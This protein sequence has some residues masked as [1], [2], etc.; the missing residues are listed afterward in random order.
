MVTELVHNRP[1]RPCKFFWSPVHFFP[2]IKILSLTKRVYSGSSELSFQIG[3][4]FFGFPWLS[5]HC[6]I[7]AKNPKSVWPE[8]RTLIALACLSARILLSW[9]SQNLP[10]PPRFPLSNFYSLAPHLPQSCSWAINSHFSLLYF[11]LS[12]LQWSLHLSWCCWIKSALW[13]FNKCHE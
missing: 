3:L 2:V 13:F 1:R 7:L 10:L 8:S 5:L 4:D 6:P 11:E 9:F 12:P